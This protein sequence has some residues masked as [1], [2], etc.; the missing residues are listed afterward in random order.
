[1]LLVQIDGACALWASAGVAKWRDA[2]EPL[3][4]FLLKERLFQDLFLQ[5]TSKLDK[6]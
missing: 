1:M 2:T 3:P 4:F 6:F 5:D